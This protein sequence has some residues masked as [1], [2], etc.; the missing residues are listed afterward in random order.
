VVSR[1]ADQ[2]C[3]A[4]LAKSLS[5]G[6]F[7]YQWLIDENGR[8]SRDEPEFELIDTG[9]FDHG[10]YWAVDVAYAKASGHM[11]RVDRAELVGGS[12]YLAGVR[13]SE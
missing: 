12:E 6:A 9:V 2:P 8:R 13:H 7:P 5:A 3:L 11:F 1:W 4:A 10:R